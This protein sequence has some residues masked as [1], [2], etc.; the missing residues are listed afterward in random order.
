MVILGRTNVCFLH[1]RAHAF[2]IVS[3]GK[4]RH[5]LQVVRYLCLAEIFGFIRVSHLSSCAERQCRESS[6]ITICLKVSCSSGMF[7]SDTRPIMKGCQKRGDTIESR[8]LCILSRMELR[9]WQRDFTPVRGH[10]LPSSMK[11]SLAHMKGSESP[12]ILGHEPPSI[13]YLDLLVKVF[14]SLRAKLRIVSYKSF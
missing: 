10:L 12:S 7:G 2:E 8:L 6:H 13:P 14:I 5:V 9:Y 3:E 11:H 1:G 4:R